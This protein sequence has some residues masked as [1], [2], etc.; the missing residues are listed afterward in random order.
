MDRLTLRTNDQTTSL[1]RALVD[2]LN[3]IDHLLLVFKHPVQLV[4]VTRA[5]ITHHVFI[6][7]EEHDGHWVKEFVHRVELGYLVDVAK[8]DDSEVWLGS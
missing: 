8:V 4:V 3:D 5:K 7:I 6:P 2:G 1:L